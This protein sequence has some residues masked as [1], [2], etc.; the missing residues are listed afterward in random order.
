[1][2]A[3]HSKTSQAN[4]AAMER[5]EMDRVKRSQ[6]GCNP[7]QQLVRNRAEPRLSDPDLDCR[8]LLCVVSSTST[9]PLSLH[10]RNHKDATIAAKTIPKQMKSY[11]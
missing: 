1:M 8:K 9:Q 10:N 5:K 11:Q 2:L 3:S 4:K 7:L 6:P